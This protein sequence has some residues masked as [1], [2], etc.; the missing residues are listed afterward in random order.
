MP[1]RIPDDKRAAILADIRENKLGARQIAKK[2]GVAV[3][4]VSKFAADANVANAFERTQTENATRARAADLRAARAELA[5]QLIDDAQRLRERAWSTY[6]YYERSNEGPELVTLN[7][8]P[9]AEVRQA[10]TSIGIALDKHMA[11]KKFDDNRGEEHAKSVLGELAL[12]LGIA[13]R[14]M[15]DTSTQPP[16]DDGS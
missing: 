15:G 6:S 16:S 3:S 5:E 11:L 4:T 2:H 9:L 10:Y 13:Y 14:Q 7:L 1:P 12:G 8:P